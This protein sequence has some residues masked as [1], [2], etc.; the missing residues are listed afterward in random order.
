M[1]VPPPK[2]LHLCSLSV[3][4]LEL[5]YSVSLCQCG[6]GSDRLLHRDRCHVGAHEAWTSSRCVRPCDP[7]ALSEELHGANRG[8]V[9]LHPWRAAGG[10][11]LRTHRGPC[12]QPLLTPPETH[13]HA[14]R[15]D[16]HRHGAGV[17]GQSRM[18]TVL[19]YSQTFTH[20]QDNTEDHTSLI[21]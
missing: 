6:R 17:Q 8:S 1:Q 19:I 14:S 18:H 5:S 13:K 2:Y 4:H 7:D 9:R 16:R 20:T 3:M 15:G 12:A 10:S 11:R 21:L